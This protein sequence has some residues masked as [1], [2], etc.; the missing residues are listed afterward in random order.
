[1]KKLNPLPLFCFSLVGLFALGLSLN[2]MD[3]A[4]AGES[5]SA[6]AGM[7]PTEVPV[8][9]PGAAPGAAA[10]AAPGTATPQD[11]SELRHGLER[12]RLEQELILSDASAVMLGEWLSLR[13]SGGL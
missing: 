13:D 2:P 10:G 5:R 1:M 6:S 12:A 4:H 8:E 11:R 3:Q 7:A 9:V